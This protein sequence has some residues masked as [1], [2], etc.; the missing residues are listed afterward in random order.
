VEQIGT[1]MILVE[2]AATAMLARGG[3]PGTSFSDPHAGRVLHAV[4]VNTDVWG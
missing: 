1:F 3:A 2:T 4:A